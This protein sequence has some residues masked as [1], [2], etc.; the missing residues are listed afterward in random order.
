VAIDPDFWR[1]RR[2]LITGHTGF[3]GAWLSLWLRAMGAEVSGVS[4]GP[5]PG[6]SLYGA[7][8]AG[9]GLDERA[10]DIR[11]AGALA[12]ALAD[13]RPE[14]VFHLAAQPFV[15]R[16]LREPAT[17]YEINVIGTVNVLEAVRRAAPLARAVVVVTSDKCYANP[18]GSTRPFSEADPLGGSDPYSSSKACAELVTAAYRSALF[19]DADSPQL[20]TARA[21][22]VIG[23][24]DRGED[25]LLPDAVRAVERGEPLLVRNPHAVRPWQHVMNP[26]GG[27]LLLAQSL[28]VDAAA[29]RAWNFGPAAED[30]RPVGSVVAR[31]EELWQG[32]LVWTRDERVNPPEAAH[33]ALDSSAAV[34][35]LGWRRSWAL[36]E[37]L[38]RVVEWERGLRAGEDMRSRSLEQ[39]VA[40]MDAQAAG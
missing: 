33:L 22:N 19:A 35:R 25:R 13:A 20:A 38:E 32:E 30:A 34:E 26:L 4:A 28:C 23:G 40:F 2:V 18:S 15:R 6:P 7:A 29:A 37:A 24:G 27:Y 8:S 14:V 36:D 5:P 31:L 12:R 3:K 21:G 39:I 9:E 1:R 10:L 11:D 17:T 16:S